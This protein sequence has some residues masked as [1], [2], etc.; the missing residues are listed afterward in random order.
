MKSPPRA[1]LGIGAGL[2]AAGAGAALGLAAERWA[3][4]RTS[5]DPQEYGSLR[6][7]PLH[8]TADD[9]VPLYAEVDEPDSDARLTVIFSHGFCLDQN[10]W[11]FQ[12][13]ALRERYRLVLWDQRGH[14]RS[15]TGPLEHYTLEQ[16]GRD[17]LAVINAAAPTGPIVL[18]GHSMGGMAIMAL[19]NAQPELI[20][21]RIVGVAFVATTTGGL[22]DESWGFL[23]PVGW[24]AHRLAPGTLTQLTRVASLVQGTRR[25]GRE[26]ERLLVKRYSYASPVPPE[27][28][29][30]SAGLISA[31]PL[32]VVA[33]FWPDFDRHDRVDALAVLAETDTLVFSGD[34]DLLTPSTAPKSRPQ[35]KA[36]SRS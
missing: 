18:V 23:H 16:C 22:A 19:A 7:V 36:P 6:G 30:F 1:L 15:A 21:R 3:A 35:S 20:R 24:L 33:G 26:V 10:I 29:R 5:E 27:L 2:A 25:L 31:T 12:R 28:V 13:H 32:D 14:G 9:G 34:R 8:V 11:H 17:L 4:G